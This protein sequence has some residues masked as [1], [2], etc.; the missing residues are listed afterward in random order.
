M[1]LNVFEDRFINRFLLNSLPI[2]L[3]HGKTSSFPHNTH[4]VSIGGWGWG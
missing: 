1:F 2:S 3:A 4:F